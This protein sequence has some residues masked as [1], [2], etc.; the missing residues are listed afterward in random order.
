MLEWLFKPGSKAAPAEAPAQTIQRALQHH[1][2][3]RL[4]QAEAAYREVLA[5]DPQNADALHYLGVIAYQQGRHEQAEELIS[6]A[7]LRNTGNAAAYSNLGNALEAQGK[8]EEA[9]DCYQWALKL[10]PDY[11]DALVNL[12]A[13]YRAQGKPE[14]AIACY[15]KVLVLRPDFSSACSNLA[16]TLIG[17]GRPDEAQATF[18]HALEF[19]PDSAELKF[20]LSVVKLL[21]GDYESGLALFENR[22]NKDALPQAAYGALQA[23][24][25]ELGDL[26]RWHGEPGAGRTLLVWT[27]QGLGDT[28]MM[29][30]Y[31][32][33][34]KGRGFSKL[35]VHVEDA[36]VRIVQSLPGVDEVV[37][38]SR[39]SPAAGADCQCPLTSL[40]LLFKTRVDTIPREVPYLTVPEELKRKWAD[41]LAAV[42]SPRVGLAWA[43]RRDNPK[44]SQRS[45][46]LEEF[47]PLLDVPGIKFFSLQK[48]ERAGQIGETGFKMID[49]MDECSDLLETS[50][51]VENLDLVISVD[52]VTVHLAGALGK[53][54]WLLNRFET[55]WRWMLNREDSPWYP[56]MR[57]FRQSRPDDWSEVMARM[58]SALSLRFGIGR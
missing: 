21:L 9:I 20:G 23:R 47:S 38:R 52:T 29:M 17:L 58:S 5:L 18:R 24:L 40:P 11:V 50:A 19:Q 15:Q 42:G 30:R 12:G 32:P 44:D 55:E 54:V 35:I 14:E 3:G 28:L 8:L 2:A 6:R 34:L 41:R 49:Y 27:D 13:A 51:L 26:P 7:L 39:P 22:L 57:I 31:F 46:R 45:I 36:L 25:E 16:L 37:S 48:G 43:G 53:P 33:L 1:H 56:S 10:A 4:P